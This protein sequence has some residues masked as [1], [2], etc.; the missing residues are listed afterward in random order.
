MKWTSL[1]L[2]RFYQLAISPALGSSC[3]HQPSCSHYTYQAIQ[4]FGFFRGVWLGTKRLARCR[5]GRP[6]GYDPVPP[7][8]KHAN[9]PSEPTSTPHTHPTI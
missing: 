2:I 8:N 4:R 9:P 3:R 1:K 5:P 6:G 7:L